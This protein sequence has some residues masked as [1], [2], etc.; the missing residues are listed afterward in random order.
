MNY[1]SSKS[2]RWKFLLV[3][4]V[5]AWSLYEIY[6]PA[7]RDVVREFQTRA[8]RQDAEFVAILARAQSATGAA[9]TRAG[10]PG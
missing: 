7:G 1:K 6:P 5:I 4:G 10:Q 9:R 8:V 3:V 2:N